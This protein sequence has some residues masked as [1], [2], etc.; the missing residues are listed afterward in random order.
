MIYF[1]AAAT[2][3]QKPT[4]VRA[5]VLRAM[6][7]CASPGRGGY[8]A[9]RDAERQIYEC[10]VLA[11]QLFDAAPEQVVFTMNATHGLN[12]AIRSLL[13]PGDRVIL[14]GY[15][16]NAVTRMLEALQV[17]QTVLAPPLFD[18]EAFL[19]SL[20]HALQSPCR[21]VILTHVSNVFG[22]RLPLEQAA[23]CCRQHHVPFIVDAAQSAGILPLSLKQLGAAFI[24]FPGHKGLYGPQGTGILLCGRTG[25]PLLYGGTG[26]QSRLQQ[27]PEY[28][29]ERHEAGTPNVP[30]IAGLRAGMEFVRSV[31]TEEILA[32]EQALCHRAAVCLSAHPR[33]RLFCSPQPQRQTGVLSAVWDK[34]CE[35][36]AEILAQ[37]GIWVRAGLHCAPMAHQSAGTLDTGTVRFSFS[38]FN[39][40][41][42]V[43]KLCRCSW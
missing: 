37:Q 31:G 35:Q 4:R 8:R 21:A 30:G 6:E 33:V 13:A 12:I 14:S 40:E 20:R 7:A 34:D 26:N 22:W 15:E 29:P 36:A 39:R 1:D 24:A 42:E 16:H 2:T 5:A 28:G 9:A 19:A 32:H 11:A 38:W 3:W 23:E 27:M 17:R 25:A 10:R 43:E 41:W 18:D